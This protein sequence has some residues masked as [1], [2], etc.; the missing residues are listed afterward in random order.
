MISSKE[1][2]VKKNST[3]NKIPRVL[4]LQ[5]KMRTRTRSKVRR[6]RRR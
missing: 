4:D 3:A 5:V 1:A 6:Q 2:R